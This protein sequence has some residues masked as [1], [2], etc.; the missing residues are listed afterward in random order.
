MP[1]H[2]TAHMVGR[3]ERKVHDQS[4]AKVAVTLPWSEVGLFEKVRRIE[5]VL[6]AYV[7]PALASDGGGIDLIDLTGDELYV[8]YRGACNSCSSSIGGTLTFIQD[9]LNSHLATNLTIKVSG[10][11]GSIIGP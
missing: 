9:S 8:Q 3:G 4:Y 5:A 11:E 2:T 1:E 10:A 7:R 6:D